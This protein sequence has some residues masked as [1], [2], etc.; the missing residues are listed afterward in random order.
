[1]VN[2]G[3]GT[4]YT[5]SNLTAGATYYFAVTAFTSAGAESD[6]SAELSY[7]VLGNTN[8][9]T[10][11]VITLTSPADGTVYTEPAT[12][13]TSANVT[14]NGHQVTRV[15]FYNGTTLLGE[16]TNSPYSY[17]WNNV[18]A[19]SYSVK[20]RLVYDAGAILDSSVAAVT[21]ASSR[22]PPPPTNSTLT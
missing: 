6:Y 9:G 18:F 21:V 16:Q 4:Q 10:A 22:P 1:S 11:P 14:P 19:G 5:I 12:M 3:L 15:Q 8:S 7:T 13:H 2:A 20:A 17:A